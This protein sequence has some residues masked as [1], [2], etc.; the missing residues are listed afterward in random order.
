MKSVV[1]AAAL[2]LVAGGAFAATA[3][4]C[5][6]MVGGKKLTGAALK[7]HLEKCC[8]DESKSMKLSGAAATSHTKKCVE[9]GSK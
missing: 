6:S 1:L 5:T 8:A 9:D 7:S 3:P 4:A 2:S